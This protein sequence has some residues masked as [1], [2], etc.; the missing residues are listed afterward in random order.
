MDKVKYMR[1]VKY[2]YHVIRFYH[3]VKRSI[4]SRDTFNR[5]TQS[6]YTANMSFKNIF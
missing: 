5:V 6:V 4:F 1:L 3:A 2:D